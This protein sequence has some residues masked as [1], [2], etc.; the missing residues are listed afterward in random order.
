MLV[1]RQRHVV[2][3]GKRGMRRVLVVE[4]RRR[5]HGIRWHGL[6]VRWGKRGKR[7]VVVLK[8]ALRVNP[9]LLLLRLMLRGNR[10]RGRRRRWIVVWMVVRRRRRRRRGMGSVAAADA[11]D[12][13]LHHL[14]LR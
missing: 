5:L 1:R 4:R 9:L 10:R 8:V 6:G 11:V 13:D 14:L 7:G 2:R 12:R 3:R